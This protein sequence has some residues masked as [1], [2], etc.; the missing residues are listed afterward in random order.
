[1]TP[2]NPQDVAELA[3]LHQLMRENAERA[4]A[5]AFALAHVQGLADE[6]DIADFVAEALQPFWSRRAV[7][8]ARRE[9]PL[10]E[11][12]P[13]EAAPREEATDDRRPQEVLLEILRELDDEATIPQLLTVLDDAGLSISANHLSVL[14]TR[15]AQSGIIERVGRGR[16]RAR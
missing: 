14:L 1:M 15:L 12:A 2:T 10:R 8:R 13:R 16:Y 4:R 3:A 5:L 11:T 6:A 7:Q 9:A